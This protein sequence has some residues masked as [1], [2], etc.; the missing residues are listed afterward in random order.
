M[1]YHQKAVICTSDDKGQGKAVYWEDDNGKV[2]KKTKKFNSPEEMD[3]VYQ[4]FG[5]NEELIDTEKFWDFNIP[6]PFSLL[7]NFADNFFNNSSAPIS[8]EPKGNILPEGVNLEK[9]RNRLRDFQEK[10]RKE[11][12]AK[13]NKEKEKKYLQS[14]IKELKSI[15]KELKK[16]NDDEGINAINKDIKK[17]EEKINAIS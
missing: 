5:L 7:S 4:G 10:K 3:K 13:E 8:S 16:A 1:I 11:E 17:I 14:Q 15:N 2:T 12:Q 6:S 9:H